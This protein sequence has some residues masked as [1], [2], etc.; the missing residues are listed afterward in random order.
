MKHSTIPILLGAA[1]LF[2]GYLAGTTALTTGSGTAHASSLWDAARGAY[3]TGDASSL[4][5]WKVQDGKVLEAHTVMKHEEGR[6]AGR[7]D[8][9][10][11]DACGFEGAPR[12][13]GRRQVVRLVRRRR[14]LRL[15]DGDET[16]GTWHPPRGHPRQS[17][18]LPHVLRGHRGCSRPDPRY[19][20]LRGDAPPP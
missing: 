9:S 2:A 7:S 11:R 18:P 17:A 15:A 6:A 20:P 14:L 1:L 10:E 3:V 16:A 13:L 8:V 4:T 19:A 12:W 5:F